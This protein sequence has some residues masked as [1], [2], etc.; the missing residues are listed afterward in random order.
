M[1][2]QGQ[3]RKQFYDLYSKRKQA[4]TNQNLGQAKS[5]IREVERHL[6][7]LIKKERDN[8]LNPIE[9]KEQVIGS[10]IRTQR[11]REEDREERKKKAAC[12]FPAVQV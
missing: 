9:W 1:E 4:S 7:S 2:G 11:G 8:E 5:S 12:F 6:R 3:V 10:E